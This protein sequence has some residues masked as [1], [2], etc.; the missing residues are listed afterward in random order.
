MLGYGTLNSR[1]VQQLPFWDYPTCGLS[2]T[3]CWTTAM[4][5]IFLHGYVG[6]NKKNLKTFILMFL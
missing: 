3:V 5:A 2:L 4:S 6:Q 1:L